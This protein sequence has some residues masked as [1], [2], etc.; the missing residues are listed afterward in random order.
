MPL[1]FAKICGVASSP[2]ILK[3][4][5]GMRY[6]VS[7][8]CAWCGCDRVGMYM[9]SARNLYV[10]FTKTETKCKFCTYF[11]VLYRLTHTNLNFVFTVRNVYISGLMGIALPACTQLLLHLRFKKI[12]LY[13]KTSFAVVNL[14]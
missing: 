3:C 7:N 14:F 4:L 6:R 2:I 13:Y 9:K 1:I 12:S 11:V 5:Y 10:E 8:I